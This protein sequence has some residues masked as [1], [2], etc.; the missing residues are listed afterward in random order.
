[1]AYTWAV[2]VA[3]ISFLAYYRRLPWTLFPILLFCTYL[4]SG[5]RSFPRVFFRTVLRDLRYKRGVLIITNLVESYVKFMCRAENGL[6]LQLQQM[7][8]RTCLQYLLGHSIWRYKS[9]EIQADIRALQ[10]YQTILCKF[11]YL[12]LFK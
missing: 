11:A 1:M 2:I 9:S 12:N 5:G 7:I 3:G 6:N 4:A 10:L 8:P